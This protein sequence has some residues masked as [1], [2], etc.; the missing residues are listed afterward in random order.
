MNRE[1]TG[2]DMIYFLLLSVILTFCVVIANKVETNAKTPEVTE[3]TT[4]ATTEES[5]TV[6]ETTDI[7]LT[8][9]KYEDIPKLKELGIFQYFAYC[10]EE[11]DHI[12][13]EGAPY[14]TK[15]ETKPTANRTVA[16]DPDVIPLGAKL[17]IN[18]NYYIAEDTGGNIKGNRIDICFNSHEEANNFGTGYIKVFMVVE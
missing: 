12:C 4:E 16:V 15:M 18:G 14:L 1:I 6:E 7:P 3:I 13:N 2:K 5:S 17:Y 11:Y 8:T 9:V 10:N